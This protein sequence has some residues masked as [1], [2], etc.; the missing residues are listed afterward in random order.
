MESVK[1]WQNN[2]LL[3]YFIALLANCTLLVLLA[4]VLLVGLGKLAR[5]QGI[6]K[7]LRH[8]LYHLFVQLE[9]LFVFF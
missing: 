2:V 6:Q 9:E 3:F 8:W 7:L 5:W 1:A 4:E